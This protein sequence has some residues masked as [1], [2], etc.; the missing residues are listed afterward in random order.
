MSGRLGRVPSLRRH[1]PDQPLNVQLPGE[2]CLEDMRVAPARQAKTLELR[3]CAT[4]DLRLGD[5]EGVQ[6]LAVTSAIVLALTLGVTGC[7]RHEDRDTSPVSAADGNVTGNVVSPEQVHWAPYA[8]PTEHAFTVELPVGWPAQGGLK[9]LSS[10]EVRPW[11]R[12]SAPDGSA[13]IF[14]GDPEL[15]DFTPPTPGLA[16]AGL[17]EGKTYM[18]GEGRALTLSPYHDGQTFSA[19]W[20]RGKIGAHCDQV[21]P[22]GGKSQPAA[23]EA[24]ATALSGGTPQMSWTAGETRFNCGYRG[25]PATA[26][27]FA[28]TVLDSRGPF[29]PSRTLPEASP[30]TPTG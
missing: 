16:S 9:R 28:A 8:E 3:T 27:V 26:W 21:M 23:A 1:D 10:G 20:G 25:R 5:W 17:T 13:E 19:E 15:P 22:A 12:A 18:P 7:S 6:S 30:Q 29:Q 2:Q 14:I 4:L 11:L 24:L